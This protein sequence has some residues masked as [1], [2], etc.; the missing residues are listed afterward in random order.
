MQRYIWDPKLSVD[1]EPIDRQHQ[2]LLTILNDVIDIINTNQHISFFEDVVHRMVTYVR[3]HFHCEEAL[4]RQANYPKL[5]EHIILHK[6]FILKI[7]EL[8]QNFNP[9]SPRMRSDLVHF[10]KTWYKG[11]IGNHDRDYIPYLKKLS[12]QSIKWLVEDIEANLE[13]DE[14]P[15]D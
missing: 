12:P 14:L 5:D 15:W 8:N 7:L 10:L 2:T 6:Q 11:H 1:I 4:M 13:E 9:Y 3:T